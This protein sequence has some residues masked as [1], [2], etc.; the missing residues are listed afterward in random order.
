[1]LCKDKLI[2]CLRNL[3]LVRTLFLCVEKNPNNWEFI[4]NKETLTKWTSVYYS[5]HGFVIKEQ[6]WEVGN[7]VN[8]GAVWNG[9]DERSHSQFVSIQNLIKSVH[10]HTH[11]LVFTLFTKANKQE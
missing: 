7:A 8:V 11:L 3:F 4:P 5:V 9:F 6:H 2:C 10:M 1:M